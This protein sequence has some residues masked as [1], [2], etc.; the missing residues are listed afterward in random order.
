MT[1][2][3]GKNGGHTRKKTGSMSAVPTHLDWRPTPE[4]WIDFAWAYRCP[5]FIAAMLATAAS[6]AI[7]D[8]ETLSMEA[9]RAL[10]LAR[11]RLNALES[12]ERAGRPWAKAIKRMELIIKHRADALARE[13]DSRGHPFSFAEAKQEAK[14]AKVEFDRFAK[15]HKLAGDMREWARKGRE[16]KQHITGLVQLYHERL[17]EAQALEFRRRVADAASALVDAVDAPLDSQARLW[18]LSD[19]RRQMGA[20]DPDTIRSILATVASLSLAA[21]KAADEFADE[22]GDAFVGGSPWGQ[23][24]L[25][26]QSFSRRNGLPHKIGRKAANKEGRHADFA[27]FLWALDKTTPK[28]LQS[29]KAKLTFVRDAGLAVQ[30]GKKFAAKGQQLKMAEEEPVTG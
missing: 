16:W 15:R 28:H 3:G 20:S 23:F 18:A 12:R 7:R 27:E 19:I 26:M 11:R 10:D 13:R 24:I 4:Q 5:D 29:E 14:R 25:N 6:D 2:Q 21:R 22:A 9:E 8:T 30:R 1:V 17:C